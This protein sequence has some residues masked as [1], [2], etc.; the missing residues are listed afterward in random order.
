MN[1]LI[2]ILSCLVCVLLISFYEKSS[3][4][5]DELENKL[6]RHRALTNNYLNIIESQQH[7]IVLLEEDREVLS[8]M[9]SK[10]ALYLPVKNT[11]ITSHFGYRDTSMHW[12]VDI[13]AKVGTP[14]KALCD[15]KI[16]GSYSNRGGYI[17]TLVSSYGFDYVIKYMHL[18][19]MPV[20]RE[21]KAGEHIGLSGNTGNTTAPHIH[22]EIW[23]RNRPVDPNKI[24]EIIKQKELS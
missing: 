13:R 16:I 22:L 19:E 20:N 10:L 8:N 21:V 15:G 1:K 18:K 4:T 11:H 3:S 2:T 24:I 9:L 23:V 17:A 6:K 7:N 12:G 5:I 14:I